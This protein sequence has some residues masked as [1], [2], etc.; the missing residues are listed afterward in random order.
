M[1][2]SL[3]LLTTLATVT[4]NEGSVANMDAS[5]IGGYLEIGG[6]QGRCTTGQ[7]AAP[8]G[9]YSYCLFAPTMNRSMK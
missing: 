9:A 6:K 7:R 5:Y 1:N 3:V 2:G 8:A 4:L